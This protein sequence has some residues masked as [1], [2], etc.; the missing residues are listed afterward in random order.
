MFIFQEK[1]QYDEAR[2]LWKG[3]GSEEKENSEEQKNSISKEMQSLTADAKI[4][5]FSPIV[6]RFYHQLFYGIFL[7]LLTALALFGASNGIFIVNKFCVSIWVIGF[8][9]EETLEVLLV[10]KAINNSAD[11]AKT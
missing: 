1:S 11:R 8:L 10:E 4:F 6:K 3:G 9:G 5:Y 2:R 7:V